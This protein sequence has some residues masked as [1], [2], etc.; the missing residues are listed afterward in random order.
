MTGYENDMEKDVTLD[1]QRKLVDVLKIK[2]EIQIVHQESVLNNFFILDLQKRL[3][4]ALK[5]LVGTKKK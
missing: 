2:R 1:I 3:V 5:N 4:K